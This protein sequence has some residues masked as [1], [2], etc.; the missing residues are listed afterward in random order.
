VHSPNRLWKKH[1][2]CRTQNET[3]SISTCAPEALTT[4]S[5]PS[6][7]QPP[8]ETC[9]EHTTA[10][11]LIEQEGHCP[12]VDCDFCPELEPSQE[13]LGVRMAKVF[14]DRN[15]WSSSSARY[16]LREHRAAGDGHRGM[17]YNSLYDTKEDTGFSDL[18][19]EEM[20]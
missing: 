17:V 18:S 1:C 11:A 14:G 15:E 5:V 8:V 20:H 3:N 10:S 12:E 13:S 19:E 6:P 4:G 9:E 2:K 16:Y 7:S